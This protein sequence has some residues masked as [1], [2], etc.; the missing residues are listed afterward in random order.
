MYKMVKIQPYKSVGIDGK[1]TVT[2]RYKENIGVGKFENEET[3]TL[4]CSI[5][6]NI[7]NQK[8][9]ETYAN[10][11]ATLL[12]ENRKYFMDVNIMDK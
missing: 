1:V 4:I 8:Q 2:G 7:G 9:Q 11:I 12:N 6:R 10:L 5:S 3:Y